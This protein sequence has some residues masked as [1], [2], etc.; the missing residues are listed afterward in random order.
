MKNLTLLFTL[1]TINLVIGQV[2]KQHVVEVPIEVSNAFEQAYPHKNV[3]WSSD[4]EGHNNQQL[5]YI[6]K[7][8]VEN[9]EVAVHYDQAGHFELIEE[10]LSLSGL[11]AAITKYIAKNYGTFKSTEA[12]KIIDSQNKT[13]YEVGITDNTYFFDLQF[14]DTGY[15]LQLIDKN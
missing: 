7:F 4:F 8:K 14:D 15:F 6:A 11:K 12:V 9:R 5:T 1:L 2:Q 13:T 10:A 3:V